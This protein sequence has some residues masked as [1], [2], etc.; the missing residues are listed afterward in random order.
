MWVFD[1]ETLGSVAD[2]AP[3]AG[4]VP[5]EAG[6][7]VFEL[8]AIDGLDAFDRVGVRWDATIPVGSTVDLQARVGESLQSLGPWT[9]VDVVYDADDMY[10]G[11][12]DVPAGS[13]AVEFRVEMFTADASAP[14]AM[15]FA[16]L[17]VFDFEPTYE[18]VDEPVAEPNPVVAQPFIQ[19]RAYWGANAPICS[20]GS[21][22]PYRATFHHTVTPNGESGNAAKS[23]VKNIQS[24]HQNVRGWCDI[25]Y[26]LL[27]DVD[28][29]LWRGRSATSK[30]GA[31][32]GGQN[33][34]NV[35]ISFLGSYYDGIDPPQAQL[36]GAAEGFAWIAD[37]WGFDANS[38]TIRGHQEWP[39]QSTGCPGSVLD[40]KTELI[41]TIVDIIDGDYE[42]P[43]P[44]PD[45]G[46]VI[47][48]DN[49]SPWFTA[50]GNWGES[51]WST[52]RYD[53]NYRF[54]L[55]A[56]ESDL[57]KWSAEIAS[58]GDYEVFVWYTSHSSRTP[59]A[60]YFVYHNGGSTKVFV[61]QQTGGGEWVSLGTYTLSAGLSER[62]ALSCWTTYDDYV[63]ADAIKLVPQ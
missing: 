60:P 49:D 21:H 1:R 20:I 14:P 48:V 36:D 63:I 58:T 37:Y 40:H 30:R 41:D 54:R 39:G 31:H 16:V 23:R 52:Q 43:P 61:N 26:H 42:P 59:T 29:V 3:D 45:D 47:I 9:R 33:T 18:D 8:G 27:V 10:A 12:I 62:V 22:T 24:Y 5:T 53:S 34:G 35:G 55:T 32:V 2:T 57:A 7:T 44:P 13:T 25:G 15:T 17:E 11:L 56:G 46:E 6:L 38:T 50:S 4:L 19:T 28:G 51:T